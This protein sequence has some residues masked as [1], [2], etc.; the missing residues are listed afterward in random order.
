MENTK[1]KKSLFVIL[2]QGSKW[3][4]ILCYFWWR[5]KMGKGAMSLFGVWLNMGRVRTQ[6][7]THSH[8]HAHTHTPHT[9]KH[10]HTH[11]HTHSHTRSLAHPHT[12]MHH[13]CLILS[14]CLVSE[15]SL[16]LYHSLPHL[17][18]F[19][20]FFSAKWMTIQQTRYDVCIHTDVH[21]P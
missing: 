3:D 13:L 10:T 6:A 17:S 9:H 8:M 7:S 21:F 4:I 5:V 19:R 14:E 20:I 11:T 12:S 1:I 18:L 16:L 2:P 15:H